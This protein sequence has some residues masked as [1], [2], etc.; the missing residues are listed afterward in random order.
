MS[1]FMLIRHAS[2]PTVGRRLAGRM[3][4]VRL[5]EV[6]RAQAEELAERLS[7]VPIA[8]IYS[9]PLERCVETATPLAGRLGLEVRTSEK[10]LE[11]EVGDWTGLEFKQVAEDPLWRRYTTHRSGTRPPNGELMVEVQERMVTLVDEL[12]KQYPDGIVALVSHGDPIKTVLAYYA[13][14]PLDFLVRL[15]IS[16]ASVSMVSLRDRGPRILCTNSLGPIPD[17]LLSL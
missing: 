12:R 2:N 9:S 8:A 16:L 17:F 4:G 15:E 1:V 13:G 6:G 5:D 14:M 3:S 7:S 10:L 11:V